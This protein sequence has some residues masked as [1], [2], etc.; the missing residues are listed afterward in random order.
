MAPSQLHEHRS[1]AWP[2][3]SRWGGAVGAL[4][5]ATLVAWV[6]LANRV[7][8]LDRFARERN[9]VAL[10][11]IGAL[12]LVLLLRFAKS[13]GRVFFSG[14]VAWAILSGAYFVLESV[15]HRLAYRLGAFHLF[16][17]GAALFGQLA[18]L[19]WVAQMLILARRT[20]FP[21]ASRR[22]P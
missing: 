21:L 14:I 20:P 2:C 7:S 5:A 1:R 6:L 10:L 4:L 17:A 12:M 13:P 15:F 18:V 16:V 22:L 9:F 11:A 3:C 19:L 8:S